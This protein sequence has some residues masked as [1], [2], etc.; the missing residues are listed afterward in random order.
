MRSRWISYSVRKHE[1]MMQKVSTGGVARATGNVPNRSLF[2]GESSSGIPVVSG[3][4]SALLAG[5]LVFKD[6]VAPK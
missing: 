3:M 4:K 6:I 2:V 5:K 1:A